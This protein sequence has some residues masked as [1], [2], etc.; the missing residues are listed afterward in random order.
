MFVD[1]CMLSGNMINPTLPQ[2][3]SPQNQNGEVPR[4]RSAVNL[5]MELGRSG[6]AVCIHYQEDP[7][8][9]SMNY[10]DRYRRNRMA[11]RYHIVLTSDG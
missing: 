2:L 3:D 1:A 11:V 6:D 10:I 8:M 5:I 9:K 4:I 7:R